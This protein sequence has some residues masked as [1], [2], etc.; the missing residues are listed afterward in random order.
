[1]DS[2]N[3]HAIN[4]ETQKLKYLSVDK[5]NFAAKDSP[6]ITTKLEFHS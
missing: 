4:A 2:P 1:M 3:K 6:L 5:N